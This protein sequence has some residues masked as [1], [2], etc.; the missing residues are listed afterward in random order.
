MQ[1]LHA[2]WRMEYVE[3]P[4]ASQSSLFSHLPQLDDK[5]S[6]ILFRTNLSYIVLN[7]FPYNLGHLLVVPLR[8]EASLEGLTKEE[9]QD[10]FEQVRHAKLTLQKGLSPE[11]FNIGLNL[12]VAGGAG[13]PNHLHVHVVPRWRGDTNFMP[14]VGKTKVLPDSLIHMWERLRKF[15]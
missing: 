3:V 13:V 10:L 5:E 7:K 14:V 4:K 11:G 15:I 2:H 9:F 1:Y 6:L 12:G 8:E